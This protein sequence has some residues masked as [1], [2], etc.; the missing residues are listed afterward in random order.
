MK[1]FKGSIFITVI[2]IIVASYLG[3]LYG[4]Y[5]AGLLAVLEVS[6]SFD[7]HYLLIMRL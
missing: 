7:N 2:G 1:Y 3:G 4:M 5:I 6:L